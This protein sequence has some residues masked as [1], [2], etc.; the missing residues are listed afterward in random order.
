[1]GDGDGTSDFRIVGRSYSHD[2]HDEAAN[3]Q[4]SSSYLP[5]L[6]ARIM[7]GRNFSE[8]DDQ[9]K[10]RVMIV[11]QTLASQY[12]RGQNPI[13]QRILWGDDKKPIEIVGMVND[14]QEGQLDASPRA[15]FFYLPFNQSPDSSF[16]IVVRTSQDE[17]S[18]LPT[19]VATIHQIDPGL[20]V[21][22]P[23][24]MSE[25]IHDSPSAYLHR[26]SASMVG[27]FAAIAL[28]LSVVGLYGVVAYSVSQ[29]TREIGVRMA[30]GAP[31]GSVY[32]LILK[33]AGWLTGIGIA[34]GLLGSLGAA[35]LMRKLLFGTATWDAGTLSSVALILAAAA[36]LASYIP[37][38]R[39][40]G[41]DP[42]EALRAE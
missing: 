42:A 28:V 40:A 37:A 17:Q 4:V 32:A 25:R 34:L 24:T 35:A 11:N 2:E 21:F 19:M 15:A 27:G 10:P 14:L 7:R 8:D 41:V 12:F 5:T 29:R 26:T 30:L 33:E 38:H 18:L 20:A 9:Q 23:S 13:G 6:Q 39:A 16:S 1:M 31:R 22:E 36:M 3:R